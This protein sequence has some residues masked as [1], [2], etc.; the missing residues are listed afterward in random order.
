MKFSMRDLLIPLIS[1]FLFT[2]CENPNGIGLKNDE[3]VNGTFTDTATVVT[4]T[5]ADN[6]I[7]VD[8]NFDYNNLT[9][10]NKYKLLGYFND[11]IFGKSTADWYS[12]LQIP[13]AGFRFP[14]GATL[15]STVLILPYA[16]TLVNNAFYGDIN[17]RFKISVEQLAS[18]MKSDSIYYS[19]Q[20]FNTTGEA[21][22]G[23]GFFNANPTS[24]IY[25]QDIRPHK[26]DSIKRENSQIRI[27]INPTFAS[28][29]FLKADTTVYN[30]QTAF[31]N[32]F[33]G[34]KVRIDN[35]QTTGNGGIVYLN[36]FP[37]VQTGGARIEF[38]YK[39][40]TDTS[41]AQFRINSSVAQTNN[42]THTY[43]PELTA[44]LSAGPN[45]QK[46]YIQSMAGIRTKI[47][48]P[49]LKGLIKNKKIL[50][51]KAELVFSVI[52]TTA[53]ASAEPLRR[54]YINKG[55]NNKGEYVQ[56]ADGNSSDP[57]FSNNMG[58]YYN[59]TTGTYHLNLV[60]FVNDILAG[61]TDDTNLYITVDNPAIDGGRVVVG[62]SGNASSKPK[63]NIVYSDIITQ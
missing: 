43:N 10:V 34:F 6:P 51:N 26:P 23:G 40:S 16:D 62:G 17:S 5:V 41:S 37:G 56:I 52:P 60:R 1:L 42:F 29:F 14:S 45:Q 25:L 3:L 48:F 7:R 54:I 27:K 35:T 44:A 63:L 8:N 55:Q 22:I 50:V 32:Y 11:P 31:T 38:F 39:T 15:D 36:T 46:S 53:S 4:E 9:G 28:S 13:F 20:T 24:K 30:S 18:A 12:Q 47:S 19:N 2:G 33:K 61:K 58:G 21:E 49:Y 59:S 57:R